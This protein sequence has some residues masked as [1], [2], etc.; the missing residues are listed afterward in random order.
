[1]YLHRLVVFWV[2]QLSLLDSEQRQLAQVLLAQAPLVLAHLLACLAILRQQ[3]QLS[4]SILLGQGALGRH[5]VLV[6]VQPTHL[7]LDCSE[8]QIAVP[9][10]LDS[11]VAKKPALVQALELQPWGLDWVEH[12]PLEVSAVR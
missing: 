10:E 6:S 12:R 4:P 11:S 1:M 9:Q 5:L 3:N 8:L 7:V 2:P